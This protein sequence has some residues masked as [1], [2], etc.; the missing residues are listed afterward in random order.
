M[1]TKVICTI[2]PASSNFSILKKMKLA[3]MNIVR[4]NTKYGNPKQW[5]KIIGHAKKLNVEIMIDIKDTNV[6]DWVASQ[7]FDYL[8]VSFA[9]K[10]SKINML[11]SRFSKEIKIISK[12]E[13]R[14][15]IKNINSLIK[16]SWGIMVARGDLGKNSSFEEVPV[17]QRE[18]LK[19]CRTSKRFAITATEMLLSM[20]N[21]RY[22]TRAEA[23]DVAT[24][25]F[26]GSHGI[27]LSEE[28]AIGKYPV[29]CV[30]TMRKIA[31]EAEKSLSRI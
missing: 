15:G 14:A 6:L 18:I 24:A 30:S 16:C 3:G 12:I 25:I 22:P 2:G 17:L 11:K 1:K 10:C 26:L 28:T 31:N 13:T 23:S 5:E 7:K 20:V 9:E 19:K 4:I 8:A 21:S 29:L 27:M